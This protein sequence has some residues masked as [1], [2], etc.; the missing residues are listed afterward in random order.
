MSVRTVTLITFALL[1]LAVPGVAHGD[2]P[3]VTTSVT[4]TTGAPAPSL[5]AT[6]GFDVLQSSTVYVRTLI[7]RDA[8]GTVIRAISHIELD[9]LLIK[10]ATGEALP[11][12]AVWTQI[13]DVEAATRTITGLR[14]S[15]QVPGRPPSA[16]MVGRLVIPAPPGGIDAI[17]QT[18]RIDFPE[19]WADVCASF[20]A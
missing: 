5:S 4:T 19:W 12:R 15:V 1:V 8:N 16:V 2:G 20:S 13:L 18:P 3:E 6:C 14:E 9:G 17:E 10:Q 11:N 7:F